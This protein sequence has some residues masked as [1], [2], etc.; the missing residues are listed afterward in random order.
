MKILLQSRSSRFVLFAHTT[1]ARMTPL[2]YCKSFTLK[3]NCQIVR[4]VSCKITYPLDWAVVVAQLVEQLF[5][6][7]EIHSSNPA[8][9]KF[10]LLSIVLSLY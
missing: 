9:G 4:V 8:I 7:P 2:I 1:N 3:I 5:P 10:Y 6:T